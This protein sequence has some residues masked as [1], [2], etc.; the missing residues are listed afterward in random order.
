MTDNRGRS[1]LGLCHPKFDMAGLLKSF[2]TATEIRGGWLDHFFN[3]KDS[4]NAVTLLKQ[5]KRKFIRVHIINGPG[6]NNAHTL[7]HEITYR[8]TTQSVCKK[9]MSAD[10]AFL[11]KFV[12]R[13]VALRKIVD[14][15][16]PGTLELAVSPWL[17]HQ[18]ISEEVFTRLAMHIAGVF[19]EARI[20]DNPR[21]VSTS[22][23]PGPWLHERHGDVPNP[24][25][26]DIVDLDG[27]DFEFIDVPA[28]MHRYKDC[29]AVLMWGLGENG[30]GAGAQGWIPPYKRT[31]WTSHRENPVY[32]YFVRPDADSVNSELNPV[33]MRGITEKHKAQDGYK[34]DFVWKLAEWKKTAVIVFPRCFRGTFKKVEILKDG[35]VVDRP[36]FRAILNDGTGRL[37]YDCTKLPTAF[38]DNSV[39]RADRHG[40]ALTKPQFRID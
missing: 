29:R 3:A 5:E 37:I 38:P 22:F 19:P 7:P 24:K 32:R 35:K 15:A 40:W 11:G 13:L 16:L 31:G 4:K 6:M 27:T 33:D 30:N 1:F 34:Q 20:V 18:P 36:K 26:L 17:E 2:E 8:E 9:V 25:N 23:I 28:F 12:G 14:Q 10:K 39:L 21:D